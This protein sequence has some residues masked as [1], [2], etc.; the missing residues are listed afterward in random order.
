M[1]PCAGSTENFTVHPINTD[2]VETQLIC[3]VA[4]TQVAM[5]IG[6]PDTVPPPDY[7]EPPPLHRTSGEV[8]KKEPTQVEAVEVPG[9]D[10]SKDSLVVSPTREEVEQ[11][12]AGASPPHGGDQDGGNKESLDDGIIS[13]KTKD[14]QERPVTSPSKLPEIPDP[15]DS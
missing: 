15:K 10:T 5:N 9:G 1:F 6:L 14:E 13:P 3:D 11:P 12:S 2:T 7:A 8:T 4:D